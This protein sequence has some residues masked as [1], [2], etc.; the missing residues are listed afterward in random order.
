VKNKNEKEPD[1]VFSPNRTKPIADAFIEKFYTIDGVPAIKFQNDNFYVW[2]NNAYRPIE[3]KEI[4][5]KMLHFL[6]GC[7]TEKK[8]GKET[9]YDQFPAKDSTVNSAVSAVTNV[10]FRNNCEKIPG[11]LGD[12]EPP[13]E[14]T[15]M[16]VF[17]KTRNLDIKTMKTFEASPKWFNY[18]ALDFDYDENDPKCCPEWNHFLKQIFKEDSE[19]VPMLMQ[20]IGLLLTPITKF[21]KAL[22]IV[23][24][25]RSGKGT[26]GRVIR[27]LV[28]DLNCCSPTT[29]GLTGQFG[30]QSLIGKTV[31]IV[32]DARFSGQNQSI[33]I[34]RIL[35]ITG[36]DAITIDRKYQTAANLRL[37]TRFIFLSNEVPRLADASGALAS[38]F[39]ILKLTESFYQREDLELEQKLLKELP[40]ILHTALEYLK[41]LLEKGY[42][43]QP[44]SAQ[45]EVELLEDLGSPIG[46]FV[47]EHCKIDNELLWTS[48][49]DL[50]KAWKNYCQEEG[51]HS[52]GHKVYFFRN[53]NSF[54]SG[55][56]RTQR[57]EELSGKK[58]WAYEGIQV[59]ETN[60]F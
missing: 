22:L 51:I 47:R 11:W 53:L 42:F 12:S 50:W 45:N 46:K 16:I 15:S 3:T 2:K 58:F 35:N 4:Q 40:G 5:S 52:P 36:E 20:F 44:K 23:G 18:N 41:E 21:Q 19:S 29:D 24:P 32:S 6:D 31:A 43:V 38:R 49:D 60:P 33:L 28:G 25:K 9:I 48:S 8:F 39:L 17:G 27:K 37:P 55:L 54:V 10:A 34:E 30:L 56:R 26:I 57:K 1:N 59:I 7:V 14:D 13:V